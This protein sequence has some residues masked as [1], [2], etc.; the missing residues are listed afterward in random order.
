M[1]RQ[2]GR[3]PL[4]PNVVAQSTTD[5]ARFSAVMSLMLLW[6]SYFS[7]IC[8]LNLDPTEDKV[9]S[10]FLTVMFPLVN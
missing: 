6:K 2:F 3:S 1:M 9:T 10:Y 5:K 7:S 4:R 8:N